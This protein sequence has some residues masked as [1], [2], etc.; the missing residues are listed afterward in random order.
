MVEQR[1]VLR[2]EGVCYNDC[3]EGIRNMKPRRSMDATERCVH[4]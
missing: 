4:G 3:S 1:F 2:H